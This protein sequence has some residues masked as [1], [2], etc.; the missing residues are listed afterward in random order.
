MARHRGLTQPPEPRTIMFISM[1]R[2]DAGH[3]CHTNLDIWRRT[4]G[5]RAEAPLQ[6]LHTLL[7]A[8][9]SN[10]RNQILEYLPTLIHIQKAHTIV[11][12]E[13]LLAFE[14]PEVRLPDGNIAGPNVNERS[15]SHNKT[16]EIRTTFPFGLQPQNRR[17]E[18][19]VSCTVPKF[20]SS[21]R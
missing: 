16:H 10:I 2:M 9:E 18:R 15:K 3:G 17:V 12:P 6:C 11:R 5:K 1:P 13:E 19:R 20:S 7:D 21:Y 4:R 14:H 8:F